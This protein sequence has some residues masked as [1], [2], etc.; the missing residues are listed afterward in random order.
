M[1]AA[2]RAGSEPLDPV[3]PDQAK[4]NPTF[5][6]T[7]AQHTDFVY[8][9]KGVGNDSDSSIV[10]LYE[11]PRPGIRDGMNLAYEDGHVEFTRWSQLPEAFKAT[12]DYRQAHNLP[13]VDVNAILKAVNAPNAAPA[14]A[15]P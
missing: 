8:I 2:K 10:I 15:A 11:R 14:P 7:L 5:P 1:L 6:K 4:N 13:P 12:N 9:G 3:D